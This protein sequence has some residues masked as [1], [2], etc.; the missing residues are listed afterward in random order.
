MSIRCA[1]SGPWAVGQLARE[2]RWASWNRVFIGLATLST[3]SLLFKK[4]KGVSIV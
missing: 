2:D 4:L 3:T 1:A